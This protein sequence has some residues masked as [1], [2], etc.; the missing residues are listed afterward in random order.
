M[1]AAV[2]VSGHDVVEIMAPGVSKAAGV[3]RLADALGA[4]LSAVVAF[5]DMPNDVPLLEQ[6]GL[7]VAV[8]NAHR[9]VRAAADEVTASNDE[10]G[11]ALVLE[12]LTGSAAA[13]LSA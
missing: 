9:Q 8:E 5:G 2:T 10:D 11:V 12:R 6:A 7:G 1:F 13:S 4:D 3:A